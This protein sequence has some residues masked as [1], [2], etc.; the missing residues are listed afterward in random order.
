[1][2]GR[3]SDKLRR[4]LSFVQFR[5]VKVQRGTSRFSGAGIRGTCW[6]LPPNSAPLVGR[7]SLRSFQKNVFAAGK[8]QCT[9][10]TDDVVSADS[11]AM[12]RGTTRSK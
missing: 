8:C 7:Y 10:K 2:G 5:E 9:M 1:V 12:E 6:A 4:E 11:L 3:Q